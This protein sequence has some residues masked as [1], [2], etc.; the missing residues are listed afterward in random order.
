MHF[1]LRFLKK[2]W[3]IS[4]REIQSLDGL[5]LE[6]VTRNRVYKEPKYHDKYLDNTTN[7]SDKIYDIILP[8]FMHHELVAEA[9][10]QVKNS[11]FKFIGKTF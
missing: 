9:N 5:H 11:G 2:V 8:P 6:T 7:I 10:L 1:F 3:V 4:S